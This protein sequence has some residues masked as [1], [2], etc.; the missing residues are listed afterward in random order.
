[1][2]IEEILT[3]VLVGGVLG[4][5]IWLMNSHV[6]VNTV[7]IKSLQRTQDL[8]IVVMSEIH[9]EFSEKWNRYKESINPYILSIEDMRK[10]LLHGRRGQ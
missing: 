7:N 9:P 4:Y 8:F 6:G 3:T 10:R 1:M 2:P 5:L